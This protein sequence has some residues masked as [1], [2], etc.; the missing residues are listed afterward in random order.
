MVSGKISASILTTQGVTCS[1]HSL[2]PRHQAAQERRGGKAALAAAWPA[3]VFR[4]PRKCWPEGPPPRFLNDGV[5]GTEP[6]SGCVFLEPAES[7]AGNVFV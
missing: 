1:S 2:D 6:G 4:A 5:T 7:G 3:R